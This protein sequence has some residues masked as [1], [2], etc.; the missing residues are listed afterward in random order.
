ML[1]KQTTSDQ[2]ML[3]LTELFAY[4]PPRDRVCSSGVQLIFGELP[5]TKVRRRDPRQTLFGLR[6]SA[7]PT[8]QPAAAILLVGRALARS[9]VTRPCTASLPWPIRS[10]SPFDTDSHIVFYQH[11][12]TPIMR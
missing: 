9:T 7:G 2:L 1:A 10:K 4:L 11:E 8:M 3:H 5:V 12:N 6:A